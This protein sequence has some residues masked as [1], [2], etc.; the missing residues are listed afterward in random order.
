MLIK[1]EFKPPRIMPIPGAGPAAY[2]GDGDRFDTAGE[3]ANYAGLT[4]VLDCSV[5]MAAAAAACL[6]NRYLVYFY[7]NISTS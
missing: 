7:K 6:H 4:P 2:I 5:D 1:P 3:V